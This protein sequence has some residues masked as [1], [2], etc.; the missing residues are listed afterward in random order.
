MSL[1]HF[2]ACFDEVGQSDCHHQHHCQ[3]GAATHVDERHFKPTEQDGTKS[4]G[5]AKEEI[6]Q[7]LQDG[8][9]TSDGG[10][11]ND[12]VDEKHHLLATSHPKERDG[13]DPLFHNGID[14]VRRPFRQE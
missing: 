11:T 9:P 7:I 2:L 14:I 4:Q 6:E 13:L 12:A 8:E 3:D 10:T 1:L 5:F